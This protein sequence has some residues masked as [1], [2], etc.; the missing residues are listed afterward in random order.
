MVFDNANNA[1]TDIA[2]ALLGDRILQTN[3][4]SSTTTNSTTVPSN[5]Q[6]ESQEN[7]LF[8]II[9][10]CA[11]LF[12]MFLAL[13]SDRV[14]ADM[15]RH[16]IFVI[17]IVVVCR[18]LNDYN[19]WYYYIIDRCRCRCRCQRIGHDRL[20]NAIYGREHYHHR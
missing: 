11:V 12:L 3:D 16:L 17:V 19:G 10:T 2:A 7:S 9:Y 18:F 15:V 6:E 5:D 4:S 14:G 20:V 8:Q 1:L 13:V